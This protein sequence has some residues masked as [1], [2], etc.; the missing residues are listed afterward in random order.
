MK[1]TALIVALLFAPAAS[2]PAQDFRA[3]LG[4]YDVGDYAS[5]FDHWR[6][7]AERNQTK[8]QSGLGFLYYKGLG[9]PRDS[10]QAARWF[11]RAAEKGEPNAQFFLG[12]MHFF[13]DGVPRNLERALMWCE[14]ALAGGQVEA[15][16]W[17]ERLIENMTAAE[18]DTAWRLAAEWHERHDGDDAE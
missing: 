16:D 18:R 3:G 8:A 17:R 13:G 2:S 12:L 11:L 9:V 15:L 4:A 7:G 14:L 5:A 6:A 1:R 10:V